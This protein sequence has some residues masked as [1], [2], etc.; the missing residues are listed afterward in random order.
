M[1]EASPRADLVQHSQNA[2][3]SLLE[4]FEKEMARRLEP[5]PQQETTIAPGP[6][7]LP[8]AQRL[9]PAVSLHH[10]P[11]PLPVGAPAPAPA[12]S[13][14]L[15]TPGD[16][17]VQTIQALV[18]GVSQ[19]G[20]ELKSN[21]PEIER[22][23]AQAHQ[24]LP[25]AVE[26]T[27]RSALRGFGQHAQTLAAT[28]QEASDTSRAAAHR[29]READLT[30]VDNVFEGL[31]GLVGEIGNVGKT[32]FSAFDAELTTNDVAREEQPLATISESSVV[33]CQLSPIH[34]VA[35]V[36]TESR[37][38]ESPQSRLNFFAALPKSE[39]TD[40]SSKCVPGCLLRQGSHPK[41]IVKDP[42]AVATQISFPQLRF[43]PRSGQ[44]RSRS[45][46]SLRGIKPYASHEKAL[47]DP[48]ALMS[49][50]HLRAVPTNPNA[51]SSSRVEVEF[52]KPTPQSQANEHE[53][54]ACSSKPLG[55]VPSSK[56]AKASV[57]ASSNRA[58]VAF[59]DQVDET[60]RSEKAREPR[61][62]KSLGTVANE[63]FSTHANQW[64]RPL[65]IRHDSNE[66]REKL[67][68]AYASTAILDQEDSDP[69]FSARYP[70]LLSSGSVRRANT[71]G[72]PTDSSTSVSRSINPES[73]IARYPTMQ[74]FEQ[75]RH[76]PDPLP[77]TNVATT[78]ADSQRSTSNPHTLPGAWPTFMEDLPQESSG[79][80]FKRMTGLDAPNTNKPDLH[81][82]NTAAD[83]AA[84]LP[85]PWDPL[86]DLATATQH[87]RDEHL[88]R[89]H[90][91]R[92]P[93]RH[94]RR[95]YSER[96]SGTGRMPWESFIT[97]PRM[98][99]AFPVHDV[100]QTREPE[101][102]Y[103]TLR[104]M[105]RRYPHLQQRP[106]LTPL[107]IPAPTLRHSASMRNPVQAP[108][109][110]PQHQPTQ[111]KTKIETC[112]SH[113]RNLGYA[114]Q[115]RGGMERL[116]I[117]AEATGGDLGDSIEMIEEERK[118]YEGSSFS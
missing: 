56:P 13:H 77:P 42:K 112:V 18:T 57:P 32:L 25:E 37:S 1:T 85:G 54:S 82:S 5:R 95:P 103:P 115:V 60:A 11:E 76:H 53:Q 106:S 43:V 67:E 75:G 86:A 93:H 79:E 39:N 64:N 117:Y 68:K 90:T 40:V 91:E 73:E 89:S 20:S 83:P 34:V 36:P 62:I 87:L 45:P 99:G 9:R 113:L 81:R 15:S 74:Q 29:T 12:N 51:A 66:A 3:I 107:N 52:A 105:A 14:N 59:T 118:A 92:G 69:D 71:I 28:M 88:R 102:P 24:N 6:S 27:M 84:R 30:I 116:K 55:E 19:L 23:L 21:F 4:A 63:P 104:R 100:L 44:E 111:P 80:F 78:N 94:A 98:P 49:E 61:R 17:M 72:A 35:E 31:K 96:F 26:E 33:G 2:N 65:G 58:S 8:T 97:P 10:V 22:T 50:L 7:R 101:A 114:A 70:S 41:C 46:P 109:G 47:R 38:V 16:M 108:M 110:P 48:R